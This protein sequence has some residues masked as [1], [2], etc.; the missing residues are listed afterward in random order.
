MCIR[1]SL[2]AGKFLGSQMGD[3]ILDPVMPSGAPF[4]ADPKLSYIQA[5]IVVY[6][7][8]MFRLDLIVIRSLP[9]AFTAEV[10]KG[11]GL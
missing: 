7:N 3:N 6:N 5:D 9:D 2:N 10:H 8:N 4:L 11:L 1:D